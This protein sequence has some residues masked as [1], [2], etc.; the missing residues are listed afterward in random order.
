[1]GPRLL[2]F[3]EPGRFHVDYVLIPY[4]GVSSMDFRFRLATPPGE[5]ALLD[6]LEGA[7]RA[8]E[9]QGLYS[10]SD[11]DSGPVL[12][13]MSPESAILL[14]PRIRLNGERLF[15]PACF[16]NENS[17]TRYLDLLAHLALRGA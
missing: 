11:E 6:A 9:L 7:C 2:P 16:D 13:A 4:T 15:L 17:A 14:R 8:G 5:A 10:L 3:L 12:W 1:M